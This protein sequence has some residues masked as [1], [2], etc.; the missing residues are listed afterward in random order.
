[1]LG[2]GF[3]QGLLGEIDLVGFQQRLAD[4]VSLRLQERVG[5]AAANDERIDLAHQVVNHANLVADLGSAEDRHKRLLR[6]AERLAEILEFLL[7]QQA[8]RR[9]FPRNA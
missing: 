7:H 6:M 2:L 8:R 5:H 1:M 3:C 4:L 9:S